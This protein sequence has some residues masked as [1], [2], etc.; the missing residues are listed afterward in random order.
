MEQE[1]DGRDLQVDNKRNTINLLLLLLFLLLLLLFS[2]YYQV[3][4]ARVAYLEVKEWPISFT[5]FL[6]ITL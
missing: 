5:R 4:E 6:I 3:I 2:D 1:E